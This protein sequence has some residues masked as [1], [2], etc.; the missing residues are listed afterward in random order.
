MLQVI[1][2]TRTVAGGVVDCIVY[3]SCGLGVSSAN[4][5]PSPAGTDAYTVH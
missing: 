4:T 1:F 2:Q 3:I 5:N